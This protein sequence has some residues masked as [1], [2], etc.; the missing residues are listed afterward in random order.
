MQ[1]TDGTRHAVYIRFRPGAVLPLVG[2]LGWSVYT[3][4]V[5]YPGRHAIE[6]ICTQ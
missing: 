1:F 4:S 6:R 5:A 2:Q 3:F